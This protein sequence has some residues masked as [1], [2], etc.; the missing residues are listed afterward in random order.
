MTRCR[1]KPKRLLVLAALLFLSASVA[2][3]GVARGDTFHLTSGGRVEGRWVNRLDRGADHYLIETAAGVRLRLSA[4]AVARVEREKSVLAV[5]RRLATAAPDTAAGH[6][7]MAEWCREQRLDKER[8]A[9]L[10]RILVHDTDHAAARRL[11]GYSQVE[12]QWVRADDWRRANGYRRYNGR[13]LLPQH[14]ELIEKRRQAEAAHEKW[15][16][17]LAAWRQAR[18]NAALAA[19][20]ELLAVRD[21]KAISALAEMLRRD[22]DR[23]ARELYVQVLA[24][25]NDPAAVEVLFAHSLGDFDEEIRLAALEALIERRPPGIVGRYIKVLKDGN[26]VRVN[27]AARALGRLGD[28]V[29]LEPLIDALYTTHTVAI[30]PAGSPDTI[31]TTF[32]NPGSAG[33]QGTAFRTGG[34]AKTFDR[35]VANPEVLT[36]LVRLSGGQSFNYDETAWRNW[37]IAYR[38]RP[39]ARPTL[40]GE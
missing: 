17:K 21:P 35:T 24:R 8:L 19:R 12:G 39:T 32:T 23:R 31:S 4:T 16:D 37:L 10:E 38:N 9:H 33:G 34:K 22:G 7:S 20:R 11:L 27:L 1:Q 15:L 28:D 18:D 2:P 40:R 6:W 25:I 14:I 36:A 29:A 26:N 13:W 5:Y 3:G 30:A